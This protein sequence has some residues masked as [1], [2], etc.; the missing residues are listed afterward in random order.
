VS[1]LQL[2]G[3]MKELAAARADGSDAT[4][5]ASKT[6]RRALQDC[7][8]A[9]GE[10]DTEMGARQA[11]YDAALAAH[12]ELLANIQV[13]GWGYDRH[14]GV[15]AGGSLPPEGGCRGPAAGREEHCWARLGKGLYVVCFEGVGARV[16]W[17]GMRCTCEK[18]MGG[19]QGRV[20]AGGLGPTLGG[21]AHRTYSVWGTWR[22]VG[23]GGGLC[24][25]PRPAPPLGAQAC[26]SGP[27]CFH[28]PCVLTTHQ[29]FSATS[30]SA[31]GATYGL[32]L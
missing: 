16:E 6:R 27:S 8:V 5:A 32:G 2:E 12:T 7:E 19:W 26:G 17:I 30:P 29:L 22:E 10:Y 18:G 9:I 3:R 4:A 23:E 11:E 1:A 21:L 25:A 13:W 24:S 31:T 14:G 20:G 28:A 15:G